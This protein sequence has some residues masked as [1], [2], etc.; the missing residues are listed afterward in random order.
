MPPEEVTVNIPIPPGPPVWK[1]PLDVI[2]MGNFLNST[3]PLHRKSEKDPFGFYWKQSCPKEPMVRWTLTCEEFRHQV[4]QKEFKIRVNLKP[5]S[6][7]KSGMISIRVSA[8]N[9]RVPI[10]SRIDI[11][12]TESE[13][14]TFNVAE[15]QL[16]E[17]LIKEP[18]PHKY[19]WRSRGIRK[20]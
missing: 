17:L 14:D 6:R 19:G 13:G 18:T 16:K 3:Y 4:E 1:N 20:D 12:V 11:K 15:A 5:A 8:S 10:E 9:I 2:A 7:R